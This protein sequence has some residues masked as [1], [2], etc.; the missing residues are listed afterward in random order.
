[1]TTTARLALLLGLLLG[2][3]GCDQP[4]MRHQ[5]KYLPYQAAP[6]F[7]QG[8]AAL[9]PPANTVARDTLPP[10]MP[11]PRPPTTLALL[12][13]GQDRFDAFCAPCHNELGDGRG[14]IV[15]RGFPSPPSFHSE[16]LRQ[17]NDEQIY[18][19]ITHG[20]GIMYSYADRVPGS[21]RWAIIAYIRALQLS[22]HANVAEL[23][24]DIRAQLTMQGRP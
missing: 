13:R 11:A 2:L 15:Q 23:P 12:R 14:M 22:Q 1:M 4:R 6:D 21:D 9:H 20:Y 5:P 7:K 18:D 10:G 16:R 19:V 3:T 8:Y 17:L 24:A